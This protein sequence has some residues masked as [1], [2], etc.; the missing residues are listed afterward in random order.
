[1]KKIIL[2]FSIVSII[3]T[4]N[5]NAQIN[6]GVER[7]INFNSLADADHWKNHDQLKFG[8]NGA[9]IA[10]IPLGCNHRLYVQPSLGYIM[11]GAEDRFVLYRVV[12]GQSIVQSVRHK[13]TLNYA[14]LPVNLIYH[15]G[16][17]DCSH[18][19]VGAGGYVAR[20]LSARIKDKVH[21]TIDGGPARVLSMSIDQLVIG[22]AVNAVDITRIDI[23]ANLLIGWQINKRAYVKVGA[24]YS[25]RD[26]VPDHNFFGFNNRPYDYFLTLGTHFKHKNDCKNECKNDKHKEKQA[27]SPVDKDDDKDAAE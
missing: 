1:M 11:K 17:Q 23:G 19:F 9:W 18:F 12:D 20:L 16:D 4:N 21:T 8:I 10:D 25:F 7:G 14:I 27:N 5:I 13:L 26:L 24:S 15:F 3:A 22:D 6:F 2:L